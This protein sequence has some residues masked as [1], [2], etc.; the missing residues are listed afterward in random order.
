[1]IL[2]VTFSFMFTCFFLP[3]NNGYMFFFGTKSKGEMPRG[4]LN[5]AYVWH[6]ATIDFFS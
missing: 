4:L 5:S 2:I 3:T 1:M 6:G